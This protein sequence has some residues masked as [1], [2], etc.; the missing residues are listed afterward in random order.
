M[1]PEPSPIP[2]STSGYGT[3]P[4]DML[5]P[6]SPEATENIN[7]QESNPDLV[8]VTEPTQADSSSSSGPVATE[9]AGMR[10]LIFFQFWV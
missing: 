5:D 8:T 7:S 10:F 3:P 4:V 2:E 1:D 9:A 6:V